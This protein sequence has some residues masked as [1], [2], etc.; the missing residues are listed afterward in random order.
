MYYYYFDQHPEYSEDSEK[1]GYGSPHGQEVA[2]VFRNL[3]QN[4]P[5]LSTSDYSIS[6]A[7]GTYWTNFT[8]YGN[9]N[10]DT[11]PEWPEFSEENPKVMYF[12]QT[13]HVGPVPSEAS[14]NVLN[15]YF[16]WRRSDEGVKWVNE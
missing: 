1:F 5:D 16:E 11:L 7:M 9:P 2:Y 14:L 12:K 6:E 13:P 8:K 15:N 3:D 4:N 10:D